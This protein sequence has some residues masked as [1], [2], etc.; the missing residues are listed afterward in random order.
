MKRSAFISDLIFSFSAAFLFTLC[1]FRYI[2]LSLFTS[3]VLSILCG[4]LTAGGIGSYLQSRRRTVFLKKSD[5]AQ[6]EKLLLHLAFLSDEG[7]TKF[8]LD[9]LSAENAPAK[10]FGR[11]RICTENAFYLLRFSLAPVHSD[12]LLSFSRLKTSK[13]KIVLCSKIEESAYV[14]AERL[15][16]TIRTGEQVYTMLKSQNALPERYLSEESSEHKRKRRLKLWLSRANA[17]RF[18]VAAA[19]LAFT[20]LLSPFPYYY[21]IF[22]GVLLLASVFVRIFGYE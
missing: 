20:A 19:L 15:G 2:R 6:K 7:K 4:G 3:V 18:L 22:S 13:E 5:E 17:K 8:F 1:V 12:E 11:L 10:R 9:R 16:I 21:F 14:L